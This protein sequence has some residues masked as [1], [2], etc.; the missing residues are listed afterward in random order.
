VSSLKGR[1][2]RKR[3]WKK[4]QRELTRWVIQVGVLDQGTKTNTLE[5]PDLVQR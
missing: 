3:S 5:G 1:V 2:K 4:V